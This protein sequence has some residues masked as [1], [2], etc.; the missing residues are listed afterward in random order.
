MFL[1]SHQLCSAVKISRA[2]GQSLKELCIDLRQECFPHMLLTENWFC[3]RFTHSG[4][5]RKINKCAL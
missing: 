5:K 3:R 4:A 1:V 2:Q